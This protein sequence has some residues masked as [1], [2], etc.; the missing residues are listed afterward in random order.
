MAASAGASWR[1]ELRANPSLITTVAGACPTANVA[2]TWRL[3]IGAL[4][5][6][7]AMAVNAGAFWRFELNVDS[8]LAAPVASFRTAVSACTSWRLELQALPLTAA[9]AGVIII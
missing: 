7:A 4:P 6:T 9:L 5:L 1:P 3:E 8:P 2:P